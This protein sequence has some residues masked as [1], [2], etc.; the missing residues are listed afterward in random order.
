MRA[1]SRK[2]GVVHSTTSCLWP[3]VRMGAAG[4][5]GALCACASA[6][7]PNAKK[8]SRNAPAKRTERTG[9]KTGPNM[10]ARSLPALHNLKWGGGGGVILSLAVSCNQKC[11]VRHRKRYV[12]HNPLFAS[13]SRRCLSDFSSA[14][15][16]PRAYITK[17]ITFPAPQVKRVSPQ[18]KACS[19]LKRDKYFFDDGIFQQAVFFHCLLDGFD[20]AWR[21]WSQIFYQL[22][23]A[24]RSTCVNP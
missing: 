10:G 6:A 18:K 11:A 2:S 4:A 3:A 24:R 12:R 22:W 15:E 17:N 21:Q 5:S 13:G 14:L 23:H 20:Q 8:A 1:W 16:I 7:S 19:A 9:W